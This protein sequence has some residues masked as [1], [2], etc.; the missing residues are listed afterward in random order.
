MFS[1]KAHANI[2]SI[3]TTEALAIPGVKDYVSYKD[4]PGPNLWGPIVHD[5]EVFASSTVSLS[6][7]KVQI[8]K[9]ILS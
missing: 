7:A 2:V 3:D 1:T 8:N 9:N 6:T 4:V 5:E